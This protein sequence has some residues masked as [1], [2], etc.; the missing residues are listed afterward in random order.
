LTAREP[1]PYP[2]GVTPPETPTATSGRSARDV[3]LDCARRGGERALQTFRAPQDISVKGPRNLVTETDFAVEELIMETLAREFPDHRVLSEETSAETDDAGWVWV[4]DP[5]DGTRNFVAGIPIWCIN[6]ALCH[7]GEPVLG[8]TYD[9]NHDELFVA[10]RGSGLT[11]NGRP[12]RAS[13]ESDVEEAVFGIDLGYDDDQ[14]RAQLE[15]IHRLF[16]RVQCVRIPGSAALGLAYAAAGRY[17]LFMHR[18]LCPWDIA[19]GILLVREAGGTITGGDGGDAGVRSES[20]IAGGTKVHANFL[21]WL[22]EHAP[23]EA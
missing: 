11:V 3:A 10:E 18:S 5:V 12:A 8:V 14:G 21:R 22:R 6:I 15:M 4:V 13:D 23:V 2:Q 16:P 9:P 19:A 1:A 7:D 17:D 20:A